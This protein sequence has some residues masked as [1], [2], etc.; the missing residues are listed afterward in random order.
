MEKAKNLGDKE[1]FLLSEIL[2]DRN[3]LPKIFEYHN[4]L[5]Q[6]KDQRRTYDNAVKR[7]K[8]QD[9]IENTADAGERAQYKLMIDEEETASLIRFLVIKL[10]RIDFEDLAGTEAAEGLIDTVLAEVGPWEDIVKEIRNKPFIEP[11]IP[12]HE[13]PAVLRL[14]SKLLS[15]KFF[16]YDYETCYACTEE[17]CK[18]MDA[19]TGAKE[20]YFVDRLDT[21]LDSIK[22]EH[23][24][25]SSKD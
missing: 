9:L 24:W 14:I 3:S 5:G 18:H 13:E 17:N 23:Q 7:L 1:L 19:F 15:N 25:E 11:V 10:D 21:L 16:M 12:L 20:S 6:L 8:D 22:A 2:Q 4:D